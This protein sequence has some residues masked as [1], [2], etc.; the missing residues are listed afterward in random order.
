MRLRRRLAGAGGCWLVLA[1]LAGCAGAPQTARLVAEPP[2]HLPVRAELEHT[3]F[4]PQEAYQCGP[5]ALAT[6][7]VHAGVDTEPAALAPQVFIPAREGSLQL[8][9]IAAARRHRQVPY[10]LAPRLE[11]VLAEVNAG[12]PVVVL[13]NLALAWYP[14]WHYAV[15]VGFDLEAGEL[16]LRSGARRRHVVPLAL[17]ERTWARGG[18][19]AMVALPPEKLPRTAEE[20]PFLRSVAA[21]EELGDAAT[22]RRGYE[23]A[24]QRWPASVAGWMAVGNAAYAQGEPGQAERAWR[25]ALAISADY[26]PALNNLAQLL[27]ET[28][29]QDE[30]LSLARRAVAA[31]GENP[32]YRETLQAIEDLCGSAPCGAVKK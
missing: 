29:R 2:A 14:R 1:L 26:A 23:A 9:L 8:E 18:R 19:W 5:A 32:V 21:F 16:V 11:D 28:G 24:V 12:H 7:L 4:F 30:A 6:V 13:Q 27:A 17:F 22:A 20:L 3:P 25:R 31:D 10:V 15:V